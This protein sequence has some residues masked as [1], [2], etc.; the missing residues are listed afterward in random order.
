MLDVVHLSKTYATSAGPVPVL[1]D[2][3]FSLGGGESAAVMGPSG[4]GKSTLLYIIGTLEPPSSG[5]VRLGDAH[6]FD[7]AAPALA[8][9]RNRSIGF[10]FQDHCLLPQLSVLEN[11]L[12]PTLVGNRDAAATGRAR[13]LIDRVGLGHRLEHRPAQLSGGERQRVALARALINRPKLLLCDE[14]TGNL[15]RTSAESI[16]ALLTELHGA[17]AALVIVTHSPELAARARR[18]FVLTDGVLREEP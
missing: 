17:D 2:V 15:D 4:C 16:A 13:A 14:P 18:R 12:V 6:P 1:R 3:S 9:F 11:V 8:A 7:M 5:T 10:V